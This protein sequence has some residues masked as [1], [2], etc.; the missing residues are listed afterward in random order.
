ML[1]YNIFA[2]HSTD[3]Y[4]VKLYTLMFPTAPEIV[5]Q[6]LYLQSG[7][8]SSGSQSVKIYPLD[9][10]SWMSHCNP[11]LNRLSKCYSEHLLFLS[12]SSSYNPAPLSCSPRTIRPKS[13]QIYLFNLHHPHPLCLISIQHY[14]IQSRL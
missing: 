10:F 1:F 13:Y 3:F 6:R 9:I 7:P 11:K 4:Q 14:T 5:M 12:D 8:L 2:L